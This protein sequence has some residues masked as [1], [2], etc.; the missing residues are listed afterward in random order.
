MYCK[1]VAA[2]LVVLPVVE[3]SVVRHGPREFAVGAVLGV[4]DG[5]IAVDVDGVV[6]A[7]DGWSTV[8]GIVGDD[9]DTVS[10]LS[11]VHP[12]V[13]RMADSLSQ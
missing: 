2:V 7:E 11:V 5:A 13:T 3:V 8:V 12:T 4:F 1:F 9:V 10:N 6:V